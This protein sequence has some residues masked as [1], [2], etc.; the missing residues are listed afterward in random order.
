MSS[1]KHLKK[2]AEA[3]IGLEEFLTISDEKLKEIG[4]VYPFERQAILLGLYKFHTAETWDSKSLFI[5][6]SL[7]QPKLSEVEFVTLVA[8]LLRQMIIIKAHIT[9]MKTLGDKIDIVKIAS[10]FRFDQIMRFLQQVETLKEEVRK[11]YLIPQRPLLINGKQN[12][13]KSSIF[14]TFRY[15]L[16]NGLIRVISIFNLPQNNSKSKSN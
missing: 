6:K 9:Y 5:P 2:F 1:G 15:N 11:N 16:F 14:S 8:N 3:K 10:S 7:K 12:I 13:S 4:I